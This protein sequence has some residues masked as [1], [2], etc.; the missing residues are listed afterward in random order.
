M[1]N[2]RGEGED[3][4]IWPEETKPEGW[5]RNSLWLAGQ[6][7]S[8]PPQRTHTM[9]D[10]FFSLLKTIYFHCRQQSSSFLSDPALA[11]TLP[12]RNTPH[13]LSQK[14]NGLHVLLNVSIHTYPPKRNQ[15]AWE[16]VMVKNKIIKVCHNHLNVWMQNLRTKTPKSSRF[17]PK[18]FTITE[19]YVTLV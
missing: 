2:V 6:S 8:L 18:L 15:C 19:R 4:W 16:A 14:Y 3:P 7:S 1:R 17:S 13:F 9:E 11:R 10:G 12:T 5:E